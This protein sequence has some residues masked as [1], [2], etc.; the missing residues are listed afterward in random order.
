MD[1]DKLFCITEKDWYK[2]ISWAQIAHDEDKNEISGLATAVPN[3]DGIYTVSDIEILKQE[4]SGSNTE[5]EADSVTEYKMKH[6]LKYRIQ[7]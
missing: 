1:L 6:A 2:I 3:K 7:E 5:L 4:N